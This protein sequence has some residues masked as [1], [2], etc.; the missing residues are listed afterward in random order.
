MAIGENK[1]GGAMAEQAK[2]LDGAFSNLGDSFNTLLDNF[3]GST[4]SSRIG[5]AINFISESMRDLANIIADTEP[6]ANKAAMTFDELANSLGG[7]AK[8]GEKTAKEYNTIEYFE[9]YYY[10]LGQ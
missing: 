2:T 9:L 8:A 5:S 1:F 6:D 4:S 10:Q 3:L 7:T